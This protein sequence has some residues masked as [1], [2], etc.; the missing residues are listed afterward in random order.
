MAAASG[1]GGLGS[2]S[3]YAG[4]P[5]PEDLP[6]YR[7]S[8]PGSGEGRVARGSRL[9]REAFGVISRDRGLLSLALAA[10]ALDLLIAGTFL[11]VAADVAGGHHRRLVLLVAMGAASY[12]ATVVGTFLNVALLSTVAGRWSGEEV[13][14]RDG[15][16]VARARWRSILAWSLVAAT[17]GT[18]MSIAER[19]GHFSWL[20]RLLAALLDIAWGAATFFVI[21]ALAADGVG[22][23]EALRRSF[24]TVRR[25]WGE[26][27]TGTVVIG[28]ATGLLLIP[29]VLICM[30]GYQQFAA[31]PATGVVLLAIGVLAAV[32]VMV[33]GNATSAVFT[34]AVYRHAHDSTQYGPFAQTDLENPFVG[35]LKSPL[36]VRAWFARRRAR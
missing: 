17:V 9:S 6:G 2:R 19:A 15:L 27:A 22:P 31:H 14:V 34:L 16:A 30:A 36:K 29:G 3:N 35:A 26:A 5:A 13:G 32:P 10:I 20:E 33:Y 8:S 24:A 11:G 12:P 18:V 25:R 21:P 4:R 7:P 28:S 23:G 1:G